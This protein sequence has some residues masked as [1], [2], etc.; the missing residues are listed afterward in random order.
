MGEIRPKKCEPRELTKDQLAG[1]LA[2]TEAL[3]ADPAR[4]DGGVHPPSCARGSAGAQGARP[5]GAAGGG[6]S[7]AAADCG[8]AAAG[9]FGSA[10]ALR[11][12]GS[13]LG[14]VAG[15]KR[16]RRRTGIVSTSSV[17]F[18][19]AKGIR[20]T[21]NACCSQADDGARG[22]SADVHH[23]KRTGRLAA[24]TAR[25]LAS[26]TPAARPRPRCL[27]SCAR[28]GCSDAAG[29]AD[30]ADAREPEPL[31][32]DVLRFG[33]RGAGGAGGAGGRGRAGCPAGSERGD[34]RRVV[35]SF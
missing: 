6:G 23:P 33:G 1:P 13:A 15:D 16:E 12:A 14:A 28:G 2:R 31:A 4:E 20:V 26:G 17:V 27:R 5:C 18:L 11:G 8:A 34:G 29:G 32:A 10:A 3:Q 24:A 35:L 7:A 30:F 22:C 9:S 21:E 19:L 25:R